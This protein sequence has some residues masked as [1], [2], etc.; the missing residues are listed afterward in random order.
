MLLWG[1]FF[2]GITSIAQLVSHCITK[3]Q[4]VPNIGFSFDI[5]ST[6][7]VI[8]FHFS[9]IPICS[10]EKILSHGIFMAP[11]FFHCIPKF[12]MP[13]LQYIRT[14]N[15]SRCI[16]LL[17]MFRNDPLMMRSDPWHLSLM[18]VICIIHP[19]LKSGI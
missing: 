11:I 2:F 15:R 16:K 6:K 5:L 12:I 17:L 19:G 9:H 10:L 8:D 18:T 13:N 4:E 1:F 7:T 3:L 14:W